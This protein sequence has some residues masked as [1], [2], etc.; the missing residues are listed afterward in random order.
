MIEILSG[1]FVGG[2]L[3]W[4]GYSMGYR[5]ADKIWRWKM[6]NK[7]AYERLDDLLDEY[8]ELKDKYTEERKA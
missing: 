2:F 8:S 3:V 7:Q 6:S 1:A 5:Q 4:L